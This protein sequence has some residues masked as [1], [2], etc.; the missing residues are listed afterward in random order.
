MVTWE[1]DLDVRSRT[2]AANKIPSK[3]AD[4]NNIS[5]T[6]Q[7]VAPQSRNMA[8]GVSQDACEEGVCPIIMKSETIPNK[9][10]QLGGKSVCSFMM[11][12][13]APK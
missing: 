4:L 7:N 8:P 9:D 2:K 3:V 12:Y 6:S 11:A 13:L 10:S 1:R 5:T